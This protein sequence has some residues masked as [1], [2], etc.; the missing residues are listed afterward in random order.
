M[1]FLPKSNLHSSIFTNAYF[2]LDQTKTELDE[3]LPL[4]FN[5]TTSNL[6][7]HTRYALA[8]LK[9]QRTEITI[10]AADKNL[11]IVIL[12]S[13]IKVHIDLTLQHPT[14]DIENQLQET[15]RNFSPQLN[16][17]HKNL[18]KMFTAQP[19]KYTTSQVLQNTQNPQK[20][21][22]TTPGTTNN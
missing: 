16:A 22:N 7:K 10:K 11:G 6:N 19:Q 21:Y 20:I 3:K 17:I 5:Q 8:K 2:R 13:V 18:K 14:K 15:T 9:K 1:T 12:D 4:I